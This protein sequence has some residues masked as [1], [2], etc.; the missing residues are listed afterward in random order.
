MPPE[1]STCPAPG[2]FPTPQGPSS[3]TSSFLMALGSSPP[4]SATCSVYDLAK[5]C[6]SSE[7][8]SSSLKQE[9]KISPNSQDNRKDETR[10]LIQCKTL[11]T[12]LAVHPKSQASL[13]CYYP[14]TTAPYVFQAAWLFLDDRNWTLFL[15][16]LLSG[17]TI[18][19]STQNAANKWVT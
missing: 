8:I 11:S 10:K 9:E 16:Y 18:G 4:C 7:P 5:R 1:Y 15:H 3:L 13:I 14:Q 17:P 2:H 19:I 12:V 6:Q